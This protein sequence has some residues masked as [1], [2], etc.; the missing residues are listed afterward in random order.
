MTSEK[1][2][3][4]D[5]TLEGRHLLGIFF[6]VVLLCAVFFTL[7]FVLG[8]NQMAA[9]RSAPPPAP[10]SS[11]TKAAEPQPRD[12][13]FY[14]RVDGSKPRENIPAARPPQPA[15]AEPTAAPVS[16]PQA[17]AGPIYLQ[18][19]AVSQEA[20]AKRLAGELRKLGF[21]AEVRPPKEDRLY[22]VLVGPLENDELAA[23]A[24]R[25]LEAHGFEDVVRR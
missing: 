15:P 16:P 4:Y 8:R 17:S 5:M 20:D 6:A 1:G 10:A 2:G 12:L 14:D 3:H 23:A 11:T 7:G 21:D 25:R 22:R 19:A 13:T 9:L 18:V 24:R